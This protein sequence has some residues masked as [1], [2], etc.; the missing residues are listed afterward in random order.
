MTSLSYPRLVCYPWSRSWIISGDVRPVN[1]QIETRRHARARHRN[2]HGQSPPRA[3]NPPCT[4][5]APMT[6]QSRQQYLAAVRS[7]VV[8]LGTQL[9]TDRDGTLDDDFL[10]NI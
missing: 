6:L 7:V 10:R 3:N 5:P 1:R 2:V 4:T 8:K 9:L